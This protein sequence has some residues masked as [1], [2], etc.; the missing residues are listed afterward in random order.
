MSPYQPGS[1][2]DHDVVPGFESSSRLPPGTA[3]LAILSA[4]V[5][6]NFVPGLVV[7]AALV[8]F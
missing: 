2:I 3:V 1:P 8:S 6:G 5:T 7:T 4:A